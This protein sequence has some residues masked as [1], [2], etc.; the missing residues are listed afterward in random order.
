MLA[1]RGARLS[2]VSRARR[3]P[4]IRRAAT[5]AAAAGLSCAG[6]AAVVAML[7]HLAGCVVLTTEGD[8]MGLE[9]RLWLRPAAAVV[10]SHRALIWCVATGAAGAATTTFRSDSS[11]TLPRATAAAE[12]ATA[13]AAAAAAEPPHVAAAG[14]ATAGAA[15]AGAAAAVARPRRRAPQ[16]AGPAAGALC[17]LR[18]QRHAASGA[19]LTLDPRRRSSRLLVRGEPRHADAP[20]RPPAPRCR[21]MH[22]QGPAAPPPRRAAAAAR[23]RAPPHAAPLSLLDLHAA[24]PPPPSP[25]IRPS[26]STSARRVEA[27]RRRRSIRWLWA[28]RRLAE[29]A[30]RPRD[31]ARDGEESGVCALRVR[32]IPAGR[33]DPASWNVAFNFEAGVQAGLHGWGVRRVA[34]REARAAAADKKEARRRRRGCSRCSATSTELRT[35]PAPRRSRWSSRTASWRRGSSD[36][37]GG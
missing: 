37:A 34:G 32:P 13:A 36:R 23:S 5:A 9:P 10:R 17:L 29:G 8:G 14:V 19:G 7:Q 18:R 12:G 2:G 24:P 1:A 15:A 26:R 20:R 27:A 4:A 33:R 3:A 28:A 22:Q 35:S 6:A 16:F 25:T 11:A 21:R 31:V 30:A